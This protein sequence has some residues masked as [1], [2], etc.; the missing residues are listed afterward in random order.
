MDR[1]Y[2]RNKGCQNRDEKKIQHCDVDLEV[3]GNYRCSD[4]GRIVKS[5]WHRHGIGIGIG[6][7]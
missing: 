5:A 6:S 3:D 7:V 1:E 2:L 4:S